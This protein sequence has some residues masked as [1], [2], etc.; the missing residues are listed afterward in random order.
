MK[1]LIYESMT[2]VWDVYTFPRTTDHSWM[3][4]YVGFGRKP[5]SAG[6]FDIGNFSDGT[7]IS[8]VNGSVTLKIEYDKVQSEADCKV[9][10]QMFNGF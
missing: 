10:A 8:A 4:R 3:D 5:V 9:I 7:N 2:A 6:K 1:Y